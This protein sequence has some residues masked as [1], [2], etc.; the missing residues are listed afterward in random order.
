VASLVEDR[1]PTGSSE[2]EYIEIGEFD[3]SQGTVHGAVISGDTAPSRAQILARSGDIAV[4]LVR[5]NRKNVAFIQGSGTHPIV[6][7]SGCEV[8]RCADPSV[9]AFYSVVLRHNPVTYQIMRWNTGTN[10]PAIENLRLDRIFVPAIPESERERLLKAAGIAVIGQE[11]VKALIAAAI[12]DVEKL[13]EGKLDETACL[14]EGRK[15][16]HE[17]GLEMP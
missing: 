5:P 14:E 1:W 7:T 3:L 6:V 2:I 9:A 16:A 11:R 13:I 8:L 15:L 4:S 17:F 12:A 10:Y